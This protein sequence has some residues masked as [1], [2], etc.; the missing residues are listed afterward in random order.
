MP[1][2]KLDRGALPLV[3]EGVSGGERTQARNDE[4]QTLLGIWRAVLGREDV[5]VTENFFEAGGD[6]IQSLQI[7]ARA[8]EAGW[9]LTPTQIFEQPTVAQQVTCWTAVHATAP[10]A[11]T[12]GT[13]EDATLPRGVA[14][15]PRGQHPRQS[16]LQSLNDDL[17]PFPL[18]PIQQRFFLR[19]PH[20]EAHWNQSVLLRVKG[21]LDIS[22]LARAVEALRLRHD[23]LRLRFTR[24]DADGWRQWVAPRA[25]REDDLIRRQTLR[26]WDDLA[27]A[28]ERVQASLDLQRGP[29]WR[30]GYF[31]VAGNAADAVPVA[32]VPETRLLLAIHHLAVDGVS[33]RVLLDE[34]Q[35]AYEQAERDEPVVLPEPS[36]PWREWVGALYH[37]ACADDVQRE[38][39]WWA[40]HQGAHAAPSGDTAGNV[41]AHDL[42]TA[43]KGLPC[44]MRD[45]VVREWRLDATRTRALLQQVPRAYRTRPDELLLAALVQ[46][47]GQ[48][49]HVAEVPIEL[50]GHGREDLIDGV[51][52][53]RTVGWFTTRFPLVFKVSP[54]ADEQAANAGANVDDDP[55]AGATSLIAVKETLRAV[56]NKGFHWGLLQMV[57]E[58]GTPASGASASVQSPPPISF[59]YLGRFDQTLSDDAR[60]A[61]SGDAA[62][63][64]TSE[65]AFL[66]HA[67]DLNAMVSGDELQVR[68]RHDPARISVE[69]LDQIVAAFAR[70]V[71]DLIDHCLRARPGATASDFPLSGLD[72]NGWRAVRRQL[73]QPVGVGG[74][75]RKVV[76]ISKIADIYPATPL[77]QGMLYHSTLQQGAGV[78][79]NQVQ[80]TLGGAVDVAAMHQ[81]WRS[82]V[83]RHDMLRTQFEWGHGGD[84]LQIVLRE[85]TLPF[86]VHDWRDRPDY[87]A[88][89]RNWRTRDLAAGVDVTR[90]PLMRVHLFRRPDGRHDLVR[91]HHHV[92]TD[93]WSGA[94]LLNDVFD[95][96]QT[97]LRRSSARQGGQPE[98]P[99]P[100]VAPAPSYRGYVRWLSGQPTARD[101]WLARLAE[102]DDPG[103]LCNSLAAPRVGAVA[104]ASINASKRAS[105][106][107]VAG[108][109]SDKLVMH[110][111]STL[112][113]A[114]RRAAQRAHV[115]LNTVM[116]GA[117]AVL[118][119]RLS[120][121]RGVAFGVTVSGRPATLPDA[122]RMIG[123]FINSLPVLIDAPGDMPLRD[124]LQRL[125]RYNLQMRDVA[126]TPLTEL[127]QWAG[128]SGDALFDSLVVFENYPVSRR[129]VPSAAA[130]ER[131]GVDADKSALAAL[132]IDAVDAVERTHYPLTLTIVPSRIDTADDRPGQPVALGDPRDDSEK[133]GAIVHWSWQTARLDSVQIRQ[134]HAQY[135]TLLIQL[136]G[137]GAEPVTDDRDAPDGDVFDSDM[138]AMTPGEAS[139]VAPGAVTVAAHRRAVRYVGDLSVEPS[140]N[141]ADAP[142]SDVV[143]QARSPASAWSAA[144]PSI[145]ADTLGGGVEGAVSV[146]ARVEALAVQ[147]PSRVA[148]RS[149]TR[150]GTE[151]GMQAGYDGVNAYGDALDYAGLARW[152]RRLHGDLARHRLPPEGAVAVCMR[153]T[154]GLIASMLAIW[155]AG[156]VYLP[157]DPLLP[158]A[159]LAAMLDEAGVAHVIVDETGRAALDGLLAHR[160]VIDVAPCPDRIPQAEEVT[161]DSA[162]CDAQQLAY[163]IFTSGSTGRPKGVAVPHG[164]LDRLLRSVDAAIGQRDDDLFVSATTAS[165]DISLTEFCLPLL[166]GAT[167]GL[168]DDAVLG[169]GAA[170]GAIIDASGA[171]IMQATP[172]GWRLLLEAGWRRHALGEGAGNGGRL[173]GLSAG[174][175]LPADVAAALRQRGVTMWNLY[176]PTETTIYSSGMLVAAAMT[177]ATLPPVAPFGDDGSWQR[178]TRPAQDATVA[179][180]PALPGNTVRLC[181][182]SGQATASGGVGELCI[183]GDNL[184]RGYL[185]RPG[186]TAERFVPDPFGAPGA[187]MYRSGDLGRVEE[188]ETVA[189]D[190][191][192]GF[193]CLGRIDQQI[194]L[195][196]YRIELEEIETALRDIPGVRDAA[197]VVVNG[198][199][200]AAHTQGMMGTSD[201]VAADAD[202]QARLVALLIREGDASANAD[203]DVDWRTPLMAR[204]PRYMIPSAACRVTFLPRTP[205]G[206][207][208]RK[209]LLQLA[210]DGIAAQKQRTDAADTGDV[211]PMTG[212]T[213]LI[214]ETIG[215]VLGVTR[216]GADDD[217]FALGGHS[218]A[219]VRVCARLTQLCGT[220]VALTM[221]FSHPTPAR[222]A[223]YLDGPHGGDSGLP[224]AVHRTP[225][226]ARS[227][228]NVASDGGRPAPD[229]SLQAFDDLFDALD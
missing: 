7:I 67:L 193:A 164:A 74:S 52:L 105:N 131:L 180:G 26:D 226:D 170:L 156:G 112:D 124:W 3:Q 30:I 204:L 185:G 213:A 135:V 98:T 20:G 69:A 56:P 163:V 221:L 25:I 137:L 33:W 111:D 224:A 40:S 143:T 45:S 148:V 36:T 48:W 153:R 107:V 125:Q 66:E 157:M 27:A 16:S 220:Q 115:T 127:Q 119:S 120:G 145:V 192:Q 201:A 150:I 95:A 123:L 76:D 186:L 88:A 5:G 223:A 100:R 87:D 146:V 196:G 70:Q 174:E 18:T 206:K 178:D 176:G 149:L 229:T 55:D 65:H 203:V 11:N 93:G 167:V 184:A 171:T 79:I 161:Q 109:A 41:R 63:K 99:L 46:A 130:G 108:M 37:H 104:H 103:T 160:A 51:D 139:G 50:E 102:V 144:S 214:A 28:G 43:G 54:A 200:V 198:I 227:A 154:P 122:D 39:A 188:S 32:A 195:R 77:Q 172:S 177:S 116:Q 14:H 215:A 22:A 64:S 136:A 217:F 162:P 34:L 42:F 129:Q 208:D 222:L 2:G 212:M 62:G 228:P 85:A 211:M 121:K 9:V 24:S 44:L 1:N 175:P 83:A 216:V 132:R 128:R 189:G 72:Q 194:K 80:L 205:N 110:L 86:E 91:T 19:Y 21:V 218:L 182:A 141:A 78:Y 152:L 60:F 134:L 75:A 181:D 169:D 114:L 47:I 197:V 209:V 106:E 219:A 183:G 199:A 38:A 15:D 207:L 142:A 68:W 168:V 202:A 90:A 147:M 59:N 73:S 179:I 4:E 29:I 151:N 89:L 49:A 225:V 6:S 92:L 191:V 8:R 155:R 97:H 84:A 190:I 96:Y 210:R 113:A 101:W 165:F 82:V 138:G 17:S 166:R 10:A 23:A 117:W 12:G 126:H 13:N 173:L 58:C 61:F 57:N 31:D 81:A 140:S 118:L 187:R 53:S 35:Q 158:P 159:R 71:D 133:R 94:Q